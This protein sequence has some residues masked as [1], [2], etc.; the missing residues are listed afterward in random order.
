MTIIGEEANT[1]Y[2]FSEFNTITKCTF[3]IH[4]NMKPN[5][6]ICQ[7]TQNLLESFLHKNLKPQ[8]KLDYTANSMTNKGKTTK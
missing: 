2:T 5:I 7:G 3:I 6:C 1:S 8:N 4:L